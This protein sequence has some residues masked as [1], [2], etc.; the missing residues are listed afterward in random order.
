[1]TYAR[2]DSISPTMPSAAAV[3]MPPPPPPRMVPPPPPPR[4]AAPVATQAEPVVYVSPFGVEPPPPKRTK[5]E[6]SLPGFI[7]EDRFL[8]FSKAPVTLQVKVMPNPAIEKMGW[9]APAAGGMLKIKDIRASLYVSELKDRIAAETGWPASRQK[10]TL[11]ERRGYTARCVLKD[12]LTSAYYNLSAGDTIE[13]TV[14]ERG[15]KK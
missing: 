15:G 9:K 4:V 11:E 14:K 1:M 13:L 8:N 12:S 2:P 5:L 10:L 6:P 7:P 3:T